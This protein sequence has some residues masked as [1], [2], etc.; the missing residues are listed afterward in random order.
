MSST[1]NNVVN[2][3]FIVGTLKAEKCILFLG[4]EIFNEW[5]I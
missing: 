4:P 5:Q 3:D 1:A 2:W